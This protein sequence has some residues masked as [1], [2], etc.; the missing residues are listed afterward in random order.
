MSECNIGNEDDWSDYD[1]FY[2]TSY[3][4]DKEDHVCV[5][6]G[7]DIPAGVKHV[8]GIPTVYDEELQLDKTYEGA[9]TFYVCLD[10]ESVQTAFREEGSLVVGELWQELDVCIAKQDGVLSE[11]KLAQLTPAARAK[12]LE[13]CD[14]VLAEVIEEMFDEE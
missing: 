10:C 1:F 2:D 3:Q 8:I 13:M 9:D 4:V 12:A 5:E 6:C 7:E 14:E 11:D